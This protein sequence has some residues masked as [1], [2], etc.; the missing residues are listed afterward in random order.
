[1]TAEAV[2]TPSKAQLLELLRSSGEEAVARVRAMPAQRLEAGQGGYENGWSAR[3]ILAHLASSEWT[4]SR[5]IAQALEAA[6]GSGGGAGGVPQAA[7]DEYNGR[8]V[9]KRDGATID[10]L[11]AELEANRARTIA[12]VEA[13]DD[14][15]LETPM[16]PVGGTAGP[17]RRV[18]EHLAVAHLRGHLDDIAGGPRPPA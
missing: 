13:L 7:V 14:E 8:Q 12:A 2:T 11:V 15:L 6:Q 5:L 10:E 3:Q 17:M 4:Y 1:M 9:A 16:G 18:V